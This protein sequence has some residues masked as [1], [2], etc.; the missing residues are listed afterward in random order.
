MPA[1]SEQTGEEDFAEAQEDMLARFSGDF[2]ENQWSKLQ[3][4][5][6]GHLAKQLTNLSGNLGLIKEGEFKQ[7]PNAIK[8]LVK[9]KTLLQDRDDPELRVLRIQ[10]SQGKMLT[11]FVPLFANASGD[12]M[13]SAACLKYA[14]ELT[15]DMDDKTKRALKVELKI[16]KRPKEE[17]EEKEAREKTLAILKRSRENAN[18]QVTAALYAKESLCSREIIQ[19]MVLYGMK[20]VRKESQKQEARNADAIMQVLD[21]LANMLR[22]SASRHSPGH[23]QSAARRIHCILIINMQGPFFTLM[24]DLCVNMYRDYFSPPMRARIMEIVFL[25]FR[26]RDAAELSKALQQRRSQHGVSNQGPQT[27]NQSD[28]QNVRNAAKAPQTG[29]LMGLLAKPGHNK[30]VLSRNPRYAGTGAFK[31]A[32]SEDRGALLKVRQEEAEKEAQGFDGELVG[33]A[34]DKVNRARNGDLQP[35]VSNPLQARALPM[36]RSK[37]MKNNVT[38]S[39][40]TSSGQHVGGFDELDQGANEVLGQFLE[41]FVNSGVQGMVKCG[42]QQ[43][44]REQMGEE[45]ELH[46]YR[47]MA[48]AIQFKRKQLLKDADAKKSGVQELDRLTVNMFMGFLD[49]LH[50]NN[51]I[52]RLGGFTENKQWDDVVTPLELYK[53]MVCLMQLLLQSEHRDHPILILAAL[54]RLY[55]APP[56]DRQDQVPMLVRE[57]KPNRYSRRHTEVMLETA[58]ETMKLLDLARRRFN[59][60]EA[61]KDPFELSKLKSNDIDMAYGYALQFDPQDYFSTKY[62]SPHAINVYTRVLEFHRSNKASTNHYAFS[63]FQRLC[64]VRVERRIEDKR[65]RPLPTLCYMLFNMETL[66]GFSKILNDPHALKTPSLKPLVSLIRTV[67]RNFGEAAEHNHM[68][69]VEALLPQGMGKAKQHVEELDSVYDAVGYSQMT[70]VT[71]GSR[72]SHEAAKEA[73]KKKKKIFGYGDDGFVVADGSDDDEGGGGRLSKEQE[74]RIEA[75]Q[76]QARASKARQNK[77][78]KRL[79]RISTGSGSD[80][81][82]APASSSDDD[83]EWD[84]NAALPEV[85]TS[86]APMH[87]TK[88]GRAKSSAAIARE[89]ARLARASAQEKRQKKKLRKQDKAGARMRTSEW[90]G[91]EDEVLKELAALYSGIS[92]SAK[93]VAQDSQLE[94]L[95]NSRSA[96]DVAKRASLLELD[97]SL[98]SDDEADDKAA[99][100]SSSSD[101]DSSDDDDDDARTEPTTGGDSDAEG[102]ATDGEDEGDMS[103]AATQAQGTQEEEETEGVASMDVDPIQGEEEED[104]EAA[105]TQEAATQPAPVAEPST[106]LLTEEQDEVNSDDNEP[107]TAPAAPAPWDDENVGEEEDENKWEGRTLGTEE[108]A[109]DAANIPSS[110]EVAAGKGK[111]KSKSKGKRKSPAKAKS[112]AHDD[113]SDDKAKKSSKRARRVVASD[114]D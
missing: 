86:A 64:N 5:V 54:K 66:M 8:T 44:Q 93:L 12:D 42:G 19:V 17:P 28:L 20:Y 78:L 30:A 71:S 104:E 90:T 22:I 99:S 26:H 59:P 113:A 65:G 105:A 21:T 36:A 100:G 4:K 101:S 91:A 9:L 3:D 52:N 111:S 24:E 88:T 84:E 102:N 97:I 47:I 43:F 49:R 80:K 89:T 95:G 75:I 25:L 63:Y 82:D 40:A 51:V 53:E 35:V 45:Q 62:I 87:L 92:G 27:F 112:K 39:D 77:K 16:T 10:V 18:S 60:D 11:L 94:A 81:D 83:D 37:R 23:E 33:A 109:G 56:A 74:K 70:A 55:Y 69:F 34:A 76:A 7:S 13:L 57:W 107:S 114:S 29:Q 1:I 15:R 2:K 58:H 96:K 68:M 14:R 103:V 32:V 108:Q 73:K 67:V 41:N 85:F 72:S 6:K 98:G 46:Y 106:D 110:E 61:K 48:L 50:F 79:T 38:F 31:V